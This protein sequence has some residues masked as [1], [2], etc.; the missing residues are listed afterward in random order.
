MAQSVQKRTQG[1]NHAQW[2]NIQYIYAVCIQ[3]WDFYLKRNVHSSHPWNHIKDN[4]KEG[5]GSRAEI[6][7]DRQKGK[8]ENKN[9]TL[10]LKSRYLVTDSALLRH[11][12]SKLIVWKPKKQTHLHH[13]TCERN[14]GTRHLWM[15]VWKN[16]K[17]KRFCWSLLKRAVGSSFSACPGRSLKVFSLERIKQRVPE[18]G[19]PV[20]LS[21]V[22]Y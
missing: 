21:W 19:T 2:R 14:E 22:S 17:N 7:Q 12:N 5:R 10:K 20:Q 1:K 18:T 9:K 11:L 16:S 15:S 3:Q 6:N 4:D 8:A 13:T